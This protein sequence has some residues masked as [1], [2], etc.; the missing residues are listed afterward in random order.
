MPDSSRRAS[1]ALR[2]VRDVAGDFFRA[3]LGVA[4]NDRQFL[5]VDRGVAVVRHDVFRD[6][7]RV[8]EVVGRS[9]A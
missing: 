7:D 6:Q 4:G 3:Q 9:T 8:L 1:C 2:E 5:D